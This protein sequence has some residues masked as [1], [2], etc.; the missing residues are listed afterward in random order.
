VFTCV[1]PFAAF[2]VIAATAVSRRTALWLTGG[3]WLANQ[4]AGVAVLHYPWDGSTVAWGVAIGAAAALGTPAARAALRRVAWPATPLAAFA[5][6]VAAFAAYELALYA[7]AVSVLGGAS[8]FA[9]SVVGQVLLINGVTL[10]GLYGLDQI[11]AALEA[12]LL[13]RRRVGAMLR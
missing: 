3:L 6:F 9:P 10:V 2:G 1:T 4:A 8:A 11:V 7:V 13:R 5:A 12:A